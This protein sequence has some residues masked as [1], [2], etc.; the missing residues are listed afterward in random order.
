MIL[1]KSAGFCAGV[2]RAVD[3]TLHASAGKE[4]NIATYGPLVH[5]PQ[6]IE[7]LRIRE[8][9]C[10]ATVDEL[11]EGLAIIRSHGVSPQER[12]QIERRGLRILDA[13]CPKVGKVHKLVREH[14][15]N[16][17]QVI[18]VGEPD[19]SEVKGI[20]GEAPDRC[21]VIS[22]VEQARDL[23][24][25]DKVFLA[26]Q[27]TQNLETFDEIKTV[28]EAKNPTVVVRNTICAATR[29]RQDEVRELA[30]K[31]DAIIVIGGRNSG[32]T[33]RLVDIAQNECGRPTVWVEDETELTQHDLSSYE[34]VG[35]T[36]GAS[37]PSWSIDRVVTAL[38]LQGERTRHPI[39]FRLRQIAELAIITNVFTSVAAGSLCYLASVL[40]GVDFK[41]SLF[42]MV[43][44]YVLAMHVLN[45]FTETGVDKFRDDPIRL[46][47][48]KGHPRL[49]L[50]LGFF[51]AFAGVALSVLMGVMIFIVILAASILGVL[52]SVRVVPKGAFNIF[53]FRR[54]KDIAASKN[55][56]VASAWAVVSVFPLFY[57]DAH[58]NFWRTLAVF[59]FLFL[60]TAIR[61]IFLDLSDIAG[62]KLVGRDSV[63]IVI[64][65]K[66]TLKLIR[67]MV[68]TLFFFCYLGA[69]V[70]LLPSLSYFVAFWILIEYILLVTVF[71]RTASTFS[72]VLRDALVDGHFVLAGVVA[73][74]WMHTAV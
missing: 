17:Y 44:F 2:R 19:H 61:S 33:K 36:A 37:T 54:L 30:E 40:L 3:M 5:N 11:Q 50:G 70:G 62:D 69:Y 10:A 15:E 18:I 72:L 27:T 46:N 47:F 45:R 31:V 48:Y 32:N 4:G 35:V 23:P 25:F 63:P 43:F 39:R 24:S 59:F 1:A 58:P 66:S 52:Y 20:V 22:T 13:T 6:V 34:T 73:W 55:F 9:E 28:I 51:A 64:G 26:A 7:L 68:V 8:V 12:E 38:K 56:F 49:M 41:F 65:E 42:A 14:A 60:V 57:L 74:L 16:G 21:I 29:K 71:R 53:G 67:G